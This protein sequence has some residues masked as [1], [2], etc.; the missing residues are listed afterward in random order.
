MNR[1]QRI[2]AL[3]RLLRGRRT[4]I[5]KRDIQEHL[6]CSRA[7]ANRV[8]EDMRLYLGA[9][10]AYDRDRG[11]YHYDLRDGEHYEL[12]GLWFSPTEI[13]ALLTTMKLLS[14]VRP[15]LLGALVA[16][17][18]ERIERIVDDK[19][20]GAREFAKRVRI[21]PMA[22]RKVDMNTFQAAANALV[23][24]ARLRILYH[25]R[26]RDEPTERWISPQRLVYYR[27]NWYL[28]AWCHAREG[29]RS[30]ALDRM[31]VAELGE[32]ALNIEDAVLHQHF[33][34][35]Y[36]IFAGAPTATAVLRFSSAA[37]RWVADEY[38]HP[39]QELTTL[40]DGGAELRLPYSDPRELIMEILKYGPEVEVVEPVELRA[41]IET[42]LRAALA[43][44][45]KVTPRD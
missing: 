3:H 23:S 31:H 22:T 15:G 28:D 40:S 12:P 6:A 16:P 42:R 9:P 32:A 39:K 27:D 10:I 45:G 43:H 36:G 2:Y 29:L 35:A 41:E 38:W 25:G 14:D 13:S 19:R 24:R 34:T 37:A 26:A 11:G 1:L 33:A 8:I 44:Y 5:P 30:F 18:R 21:L 4:A 7:T 20:T 17:L